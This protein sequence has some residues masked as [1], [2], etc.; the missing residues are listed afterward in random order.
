M[1][2]LFIMVPGTVEGAETLAVATTARQPAPPSRSL[3]RLQTCACR[4]ASS[5]VT[6][7]AVQL[8]R[9]PAICRIPCQERLRR[10]RCCERSARAIR[11]TAAGQTLNAAAQLQH[12]ILIGLSELLAACVIM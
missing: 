2:V 10:M 12:D 9:D 8:P 3:H 11:A 6:M 1:L 7:A 5:F 4:F